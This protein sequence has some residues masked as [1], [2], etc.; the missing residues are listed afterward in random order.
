[1]KDA[2]TKPVRVL[3]AE[4]HAVVREGTRR[5]LERDPLVETVGE[6]EDGAQAVSLAAELQPD[7]VLLDLRLPVLSGIDAVSR[8]REVSPRTRVLILSAYD[9]DDYVFAALEA[10]A[11]GYLL[12]TAHGSE[13]IDAIHSVHRGDVV[14]HPIIAAKLVRARLAERQHSGQA[15]DT[16]TDRED[17]ILRLA[18]KGLRNKDIARDLGLSTRTVEGHLSHIFAKLGVSSRT[19]AIIFGASHHWYKLEG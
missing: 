18:A 6:A 16:L 9:D 1:V 10:G 14:L 2:M 4:D 11:A 7:I 13:V 12:K 19:E 8:I 3:I 15:E 17:D 5:I